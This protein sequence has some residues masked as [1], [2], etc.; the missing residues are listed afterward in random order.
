MR[1]V[2]FDSEAEDEFR[3]AASYYENQ[4]TGLGDDFVAEVEQAVQRIA[5]MPQAFPP[6]G[7]SELPKCILH[8]FPYTLFFLELQDRAWIAAVAQQRRR[9]G[10]W[11]HRRP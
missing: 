7:S 6:H 3:A 10:Y 4:R 8:R 5:Q 11:S 1:P 2:T 9:P